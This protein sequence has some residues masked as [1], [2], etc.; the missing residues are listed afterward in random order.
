MKLNADIL[1]QILKG[2]FNSQRRKAGLQLFKSGAVIDIENGPNEVVAEVEDH[3]DDW[4]HE[5]AI[6]KN[7]RAFS[8]MCS[9]EEHG[10]KH[11]AAMIYY[12]LDQLNVKLPK[13]TT[14]AK[15]NSASFKVPSISGNKSSEFRQLVLNSDRIR[16]DLNLLTK[17]IR[18]QRLDWGDKLETKFI[19]PEEIELAI[20]NDYNYSYRSNE[21]SI[22]LKR[23]EKRIL[24]KCL[25]CNKKTTQ[26]C[27]H[28]AMIL[29]TAA[30]FL[31]NLGFLSPE[32]SYANL[33][34]NAAKEMNVS[35]DAF[36]K[37][38][39]LILSSNGLKVISKHPNV[40]DSR[41][42]NNLQGLLDTTK[43]NRK[44]LAQHELQR[45]EE[46]RT[47]KHAF[48]WFDGYYYDDEHIGIR[49]VSGKGLKT[50]EGIQSSGRKVEQLPRDLP[51]VHQRIAK[52]LFFA[53]E[54]PDPELRFTKV[55]KILEDHLEE[56]N[57]IYQFTYHENPDYDTIRN[58]DL[59]IV[60]F[61]PEPLQA[62]LS[63]F[64]EDGLLHF[65]C[66]ITHQGKRIENTKLTFTN[67]VFS[68]TDSEAYLHPNHQFANLAR[69]FKESDTMIITRADQQNITRLVE[70]FRPYF[71]IDIEP[72][73][74]LEGTTLT[75]PI[76]QVLLREVGN[77]VL[78]EPR[79]KYGEYSFNAF[80]EEDY[81]IQD[82]QVLRMDDTDRTFLVDFIRQS[83][84]DFDKEI[85]VQDYVFLE[86]K[87]LLNNYWFARFNE[88]CEAAGIKVL[89]QKQLSKFK[90]SK[91]RANAFSHVKSGIDWF[92]VDMGVSFGKE[93]VKPAD[94]IRAL[95]NKESFVTL[96]DGSLGILPEEWLEQA[97]KILAVAD[98]DKEDIKIS[99]Y[100]FNV[101]DDLFEDID[102]KKIVKE[103]QE[104]K[105]KLTNYDT[106]KKYTVPKNIKADLRPYQKHGFA[107]LKFLD[108]SGFGGILA[109]DMGL[110]KTLQVICLLADRPDNNRENADPSLVVVPRSLL[111]NWAAELDKFCPDLTYIIHHGQGRAKKLQTLLEY[112][113][114]IT[115][116][117]TAA[118][119]IEMLKPFK[120]DYIIL[121]ESQ[122]I[123]NTGSRRYKA[124]RLLQSRNKIAMTGTPI[125]NNT[126]DLYA[127]LSFTSPG[128][129]GTQNR[130]RQDFAVPI[131]NHGDTEAAELLRRLIH[132]FV[133][134][135]TKE[136]VAKDL[137]E[138]TESIIYCDMGT[139]QRKLYNKLKEQIKQDI[140]AEVEA[141]GVAKSKFKMLDGL[142]RL[143]Q[144]CNSPLLLNDSFTGANADSVKINILLQNLTEELDHHSALVFSQF[145][146][147][148]A[149][150]RKELDKRGIKYA[151]L[152]GSTVKR[153]EEVDKF[154][155]RDDIQIFLISIKAGNT[156]MNLTKADYV[157]I[158]DP[159]WN[160]AVEAQAIDRTH[161]IGQDKQVF[162]YKL[163]CKDSIEEKILKLQEKKKTLAQDI[164]RTDDNVLKSLDKNELLALFD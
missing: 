62:K 77:F 48:L 4:I 86:V 118:A 101:V 138:K 108:E 3:Q 52:A 133:L 156:G 1:Q 31:K 160:P 69:M 37:Y 94:W 76:Y 22:R 129:L 75:D 41:W 68:A 109:D 24:I 25:S 104:K 143:R 125:E 8:A 80:D 146:S 135:R 136:Q 42:V 39:E 7:G 99:K 117:D 112:K 121:D 84:P 65:R 127:Q 70:G 162:A 20:K 124:M 105:R 95:R 17:G 149:I 5:P 59:K 114:I 128:L 110:G 100:R 83:H 38:F 116:Y 2:Q 107:W 154:M 29:N 26:L 78:F 106:N 28:Q 63:L 144:M 111:H 51:P 36:D 123:K 96:K 35:A 158:L 115:T 126:L 131:D 155:N 102:D 71:N 21:S 157:Y 53:V 137:P 15:T 14:A 164:I 74:L 19:S 46:G 151:Y 140:E 66:Q 73:I 57:E 43:S 153:Q 89:G 60:S 10:C 152:D 85:Q 81:L 161:R 54:E 67:E 150:V 6:L 120:F 30:D 50:K 132:P 9:C 87:E 58:P 88:A 40:V 18:I 92:E 11:I 49:F 47:K 72:G 45:L 130:F 90:Y 139:T 27:R 33:I 97:R 163:I 34:E 16:G 61:Q 56:L 32:F 119:D 145:T 147:L 44:K 23:D 91:H 122:A 159:W 13:T 134:R 113:V 103:L 148:L 12:L 79:L 55:Q 82:N 141:K 98:I 93:V 64:R 142:L